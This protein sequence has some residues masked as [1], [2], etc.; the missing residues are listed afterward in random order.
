MA[1][2]VYL[3]RETSDITIR[4][5]LKEALTHSSNTFFAAAKA[6]IVLIQ[7]SMIP[8]IVVL[9]YRSPLSMVERE[10]IS[11]ENNV[12]FILFSIPRANQSIKKIFLKVLEKMFS[13]L[14]I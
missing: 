2:V 12:H 13:S 1:N 3:I 4:N 8:G 11:N 5:L 10:R 14:E 6:S 7:I 9:F